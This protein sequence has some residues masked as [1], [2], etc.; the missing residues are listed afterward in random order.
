MAL[1]IGGTPGDWGILAVVVLV[2][3]GALWCVL[4]KTFKK[5]IFLEHHTH[6]K[7]DR[8]AEMHQEG[9][10][11]V[12]VTCS[13]WGGMAQRKPQAGQGPGAPAVADVPFRELVVKCHGP[14]APTW[15]HGSDRPACGR[16]RGADADSHVPCGFEWMPVTG[17]DDQVVLVYG[18]SDPDAWIGLLK[19]SRPRHLVAVDASPA[20][21][22]VAR[23]RLARESLAAELVLLPAAGLPL[24]LGDGAI[25]Y[26][27]CVGGLHHA[28]PLEALFTE[29]ARV[30]GAGGSARI[31]VP[32]RKS[33]WWHLCAALPGEPVGSEGD[34]LAATSWPGL[35]ARPRSVSQAYE[36]EEVVS[37][38]QAAGLRARRLGSNVSAA[39]MSLLERRV[40]LLAS[41]ALPEEH[42]QFLGSLGF[43]RWGRPLH[44]GRVAGCETVFVLSL[45]PGGN[46]TPA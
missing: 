20:V 35:E 5:L 26:I 3:L 29:F 7:M 13:R 19:A 36:E 11:Q 30:L 43:D 31:C 18:C 16:H 32:D 38:A 4:D 34:G 24:P 25:D 44:H 45:E 17:H 8:L 1:V 9:T 14:A 23:R 42:R 22:E 27:H 37:A 15:A 41:D 21:L 40:E 46:V 10:V 33:L 2:V 6:V 28:S 12:E 39:E